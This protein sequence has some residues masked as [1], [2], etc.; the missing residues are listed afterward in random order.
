M[1]IW[2]INAMLASISEIC[3]LVEILVTES[4][5]F[6]QDHLKIMYYLGSY[7]YQID[8]FFFFLFFLLA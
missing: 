7:V 4:E 8:F 6:L 5:L 2:N 1:H 3:C